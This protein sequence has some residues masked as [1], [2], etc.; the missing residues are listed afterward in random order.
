MGPVAT[1]RLSTLA[2]A[3]AVERGLLVLVVMEGTERTRRGFNLGSPTSI[4]SVKLF[5]A[6]RAVVVGKAQPPEV[7]AA[8]VVSE[9]AAVVE[10]IRARQAHYPEQ[11]VTEGSELGAAAAGHEIQPAPRLVRVVVAGWAAVVV[12]PAMTLRLVRLVLVVP[13]SS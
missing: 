12:V 5:G 13:A 3:A 1:L 2:V 10:H 9:P 11:E 6:A 7:T 4:F 8:M